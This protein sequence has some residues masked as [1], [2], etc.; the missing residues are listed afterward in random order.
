MDK[1]QEFLKKLLATFQM[2]AE[3]N[4]KSMSANLID[5]EKKPSDSKT[6][7]LVE[8]VFREAH[9]LKGASRVVNLME[10]ESVCHSFENIMSALKNNII[11]L[12]PKIFDMLH[13]A[14]DMIDNLLVSSES[15]PSHEQRDQV[16]KLITELS[17]VEAGKFEETEEEAITQQR[18]IPLE[19]DQ[20]L[21]K[22]T[23]YPTIEKS[24]VTKPE[25]KKGTELKKPSTETIRVSINKLD[26]LLFQA[27]E[28][29]ALEL[30][31]IQRTK[32]LRNIFESIKILQKESSGVDNAISNI[33]RIVE[34][35]EKEQEGILSKEEKNLVKIIQFFDWSSSHIQNL[36]VNFNE[37]LKSSN[38]ETYETGTMIETLLDDVKEI[39]TVPFSTL[40][41][42]FPKS[43]RDMA[44]DTGKKVNFVVKGK[45]TEIDRRI[46]EDIRY[47]LMHILRNCIDYGI[48]KP[49]TRLRINKPKEGTIT[50]NVERFENNKIQ[51][52]ISDDGAGINLEKLKALY[53]ENENVSDEEAAK[54]Q[55]SE[56][57][58][59][60]FKSGITT[61]DIVTDISGRGLGLAIV[62]EKI[63]QLGGTIV[64]E[65]EKDK[66]T[67][68]KIEL[69]LSLVTFRGVLIKVSDREFIVPTSKI[70]RV[71]R[72]NKKEVKTIENKATIQLNGHVIP[73]VSMSN[74]LELPL[75]DTESEN[76]QTL[77]LG[78]NKKICFAID[79]ILHEQEVLVK[80]FNK[81]LAK[82]RNISGATVLGSGKVVPILNISDILKSALK[83]TAT[84]TKQSLKV[85]T[86]EVKKSIIV[87]EDSITSRMLLK[88][89]LE[90]AGYIVTTAIDGIDGYTKIKEGTFDAVV[91]D[92]DMPRMNGFDLTAKIRSDKI[93]SEIPVVLVTS[94]SKREDR[95]RGIDVGAN[96]Y[97]IKSSFDQ[98]NL[99]EILERL[100]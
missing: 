90:T 47:P 64:V 50:L 85:E 75:V 56:L 66:G 38:Q 13:K 23:T 12:N 96:A 45:E 42:G 83:P 32:N 82:V 88:N 5:L 14:V 19:S 15:Q 84:F 67:S 8:I 39:I 54:I 97:I 11:Q 16:S 79:E 27:E 65:T 99:L 63:E 80:K 86:E 21:E 24:A 71:L 26:N 43:V 48:E 53:I 37:L 58:N 70:E 89:I 76:V 44:K 73:F 7:E 95:E 33:R 72:L 61:S 62:F 22:I 55:E 1:K 78:S 51:V 49:D 74:I 18:T 59:Y 4:I 31:S 60:I 91:S 57:L 77:I 46:L 87:V 6:K 9:S 69:P 34:Q 36:E 41:D 20:K 25:T 2:E 17:L 35:K 28:M 10:I 100:I 68:F 81:H 92:I 30:T 94:L 29:L 52:L 98:S 93:V 3:E 40:L